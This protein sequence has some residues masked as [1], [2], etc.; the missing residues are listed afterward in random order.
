MPHPDRLHM[1]LDD[2]G[3]DGLDGVAVILIFTLKGSLFEG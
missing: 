1:A 2:K 3:A